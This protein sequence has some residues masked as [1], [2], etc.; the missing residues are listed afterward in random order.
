MRATSLALLVLVAA[1]K[2]RPVA[3]LAEIAG[4][5]DYA[6]PPRLP[7]P[8]AAVYATVDGRSMD[9]VVGPLVRGLRFDSGLAATAAGLALAAAEGEGGLSRWELRE[10]AWQAGYPFPIY[11]ARAWSVVQNGPPP[12]DLLA[13]IEATPPEEPMALVRA[14]GHAGD[15]WIGA[16][17]RPAMQLDPIPRL[18][19]LGTP[20]R[21]PALPGGLWRLTDGGGTLTSGPAEAPVEIVLS[22]AGEWLLQLVAADRREVLKVPIYVGIDAPSDPL[23]RPDPD[24]PPFVVG[25]PEDAVDHADELL[26]HVR[27]TYGLE[28]FE[29]SPLLDAALDRFADDP[30]KGAEDMAGSVGMGGAATLWRCDDTT[31]E[32]C[33]DRWIWDPRRRADLLS[34]TLDTLAL[35]ARLDTRGL[36]LTALLVDA[37]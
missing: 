23:L 27:E 19:N 22:S 3:S 1:C 25:T 20:L 24:A 16:R 10:A 35:H 32:N 36:H 30:E 5:L 4:E 14:R 15:V 2:P 8:D 17:A 11:D 33:L 9:P 13:W 29:R 12:R 21:I 37:E 26:V 31:V 6:I 7:S 28:A 18:A 34:E